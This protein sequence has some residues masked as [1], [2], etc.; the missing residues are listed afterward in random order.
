MAPDS[1]VWKIV[2]GTAAAAATAV[3]GSHLR[4]RERV[5]RV[6][7]RVTALGEKVDATLETVLRL[8]ETGRATA[9]Q[10]DRMAIKVDSIFDVLAG[11]P[12][13]FRDGEG[14]P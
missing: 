7:E 4:V 11:R 1:E 10:T 9:L 3:V 2:A 8:E 5:T 14:E 12:R 6:E 13:P